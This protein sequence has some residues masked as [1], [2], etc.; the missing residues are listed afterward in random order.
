[1][2]TSTKFPQTSPRT[3]TLSSSTYE[4]EH[5]HILVSSTEHNEKHKAP[6]KNT[7]AG[8]C[9]AVLTRARTTKT[10]TTQPTTRPTLRTTRATTRKPVL[11][12][13]QCAADPVRHRPATPKTTAA[14]KTRPPV[15]EF[16]AARISSATRRVKRRPGISPT[17]P[18]AKHPG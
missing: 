1:M 9:A 8:G 2:A 5:D 3:S 16:L 15:D 7:H 12:P 14:P 13:G 6:K 17:A 4:H 18:R 11:P 10:K